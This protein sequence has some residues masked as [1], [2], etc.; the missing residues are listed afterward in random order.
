[1]RRATPV[2]LHA[3]PSF[4]TRI[5]PDMSDLLPFVGRRN[6]FLLSYLNEFFRLFYDIPA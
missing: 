5:Y 6:Y 4:G 1:M 2:G 3:R